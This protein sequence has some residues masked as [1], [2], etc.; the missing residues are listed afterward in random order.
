MQNIS[1]KAQSMPVQNNCN[2]NN[3]NPRQMFQFGP[4]A[5]AGGNKPVG[6]VGP[7][8]AVCKERQTL[9]MSNLYITQ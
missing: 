3:N 1:P 5:S 9:G 7:A 4:G 6:G 8:S 2:N